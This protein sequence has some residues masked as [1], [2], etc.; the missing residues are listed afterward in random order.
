MDYCE[1][2]AQ[3]DDDFLNARVKFY[4]FVE[5]EDAAGLGFVLCLG[6]HDFAGPQGVVGNDETSIVQVVHHQVII[7]NVLALVGV[8][9]HQVIAF[10]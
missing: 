2:V 7:L 6:I 3:G 10:A 1:T 9:E 5:S 8:N 4:F